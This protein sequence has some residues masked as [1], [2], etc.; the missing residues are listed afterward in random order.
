[1]DD[2]GDDR[3]LRRGGGGGGGGGGDG[4]G[5]CGARA[6]APAGAGRAA[7]SSLARGDERDLHGAGRDGALRCHRGADLQERAGRRSARPG[8]ARVRRLREEWVGEQRHHGLGGRRLG[9]GLR[10]EVRQ[11]R[12][13]RAARRDAPAIAARDR[14]R[15]RE[16]DGAGRDLDDHAC[17]PRG[18]RVA[19]P[20]ARVRNRGR[21]AVRR[22]GP[23]GRDARRRRGH[24]QFPLA[25]PVRNERRLHREGDGSRLSVR[26]D[27]LRT[28]RRRRGGSDPDP[29]TVRPRG[30]DPREPAPT[31]YDGAAP[32]EMAAAALAVLGHAPN[33]FFLLVEGSQ[34]DFANHANDPAG[35][36]PSCWRSTR[37]SASCSTG[38]RPT[39][40]ARARRS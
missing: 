15:A 36:S 34:I 37:R 22:P 10:G 3:R 24:L 16:E 23:R 19:R 20:L 12:S 29:G 14:A 32:T 5:R 6:G 30:F 7:R 13:L 18:V 2:H 9:L 28:F 31:G 11:R 35:R 21:A 40:A 38:W 25:R 4:G 33:G 26:L 17:H 27:A 39:P 1:M 8:E